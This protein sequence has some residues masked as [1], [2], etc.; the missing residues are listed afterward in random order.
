MY[1]RVSLPG[2]HTSIGSVRQILPSKCST[3]VQQVMEER[4]ERLVLVA[5]LAAGVASASRPAECR[6]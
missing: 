5:A 2:C 6:S 4:A 1:S 3:P